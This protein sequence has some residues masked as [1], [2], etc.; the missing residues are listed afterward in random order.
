VSQT[1]TVAPMEVRAS[2][3]VAHPWRKQ[4]VQHPGTTVP[5]HRLPSRSHAQAIRQ[6][7]ETMCPQVL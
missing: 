5:E 2:G 6:V 3:I 1:W 4:T 7:L